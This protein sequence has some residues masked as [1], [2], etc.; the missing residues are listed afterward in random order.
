MTGTVPRCASWTWRRDA[1]LDGHAAETL[2]AWPAQF[3]SVGP[4][5]GSCFAADKLKLI[6]ETE[7]DEQLADHERESGDLHAAVED[8]TTALDWTPQMEEG[9]GIR[10]EVLNNNAALAYLGLDDT[11]SAASLESKALAADPEDPVFLMTAGFIADRAGR[12]AQAAQYDREALGSDPGA[13][14]AANDLAVELTREHQ[15]G[16]AVTA[17][18]QAVGASPGY[19]LGWFNLGAAESRLGPANVLASQGA[20]ATAYALDPA[21]KSS[22]PE[23]TIDARVYRTAL[24]LSKPLPP[25]WS[26]SQLQRPAPAAAVGLLA[27]VVLGFGLA[28]AS[29]PGG[30]DIAGKMLKTVSGRLER[31]HLLDRLRLPAWGLAATGAAFLLAYLRRGTGLTEVATYTVG[32]L[33]LAVAAMTARAVLARRWDIAISQRSWP[34]AL[35]LGLLTGAFGLPWAPLPFVRADGKDKPRLHLVAPILLATLSLLLFVESAWLHT[36]IAQAW[37]VASLIMAASTLL[38]VGP[39]DG[40]H[41]GKAGIAPAAGIAGGALL[42]GLGLI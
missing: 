21:L 34:P 4:A 39:L 19:A 38:P 22:R 11:S 40:A 30:S 1:L 36:P 27:L 28:R 8:Y 20:F 12:V 42:V 16:A 35:V 14:P 7:L 10:P 5:G 32:V 9:A 24:D 2:A 37:A 15:V 18:R 17:L 13:F 3:E 23:M 29:G 31:V 6:A 41:V 26:F 33:V 25:Q